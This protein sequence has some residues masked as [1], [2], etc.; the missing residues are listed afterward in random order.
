MSATFHARVRVVFGFLGLL[1]F[2]NLASVSPASSATVIT[3]FDG[4]YQA[5]ETVTVTVTI[6][7]NPPI[8]KT[9]T[10]PPTPVT[11]R[12]VNGKI[13]GGA[14]GV[15][16][17]QHGSGALRISIPGYGSLTIT[18]Q[19][20]RNSSTRA[21]TVTGTIRGSFPSARAIVSGKLTGHLV[22]KF[23]FNVV[24]RIPGA[25]IGQRYPGY[26]FCVPKIP[27]G[28]GCG[29]P[30]K[31]TIPTGGKAPY[32]FRLKIG[33]LSGGG[34]FLPTGLALNFKSGQLSGTPIKGIARKTYRLIVCAYDAN[35][36]YIGVCRATSLVLS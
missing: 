33:S 3:V 17:N 8:K 16:L 35:D 2:G 5:T 31:S 32:T 4:T 1:V 29:W 30:A 12:V 20:V 19:F 14:T 26:S 21:V 22:D 7:T 27:S 6:P 24:S 36:L 18:V 25:N 28:H 23:T 13:D 34:D 9:V 15:I 10:V 11:F